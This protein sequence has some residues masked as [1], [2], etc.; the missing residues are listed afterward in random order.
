[1]NTEGK[2]LGELLLNEVETELFAKRDND[3]LGKEYSFKG[4]KSPNK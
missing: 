1:M 4:T 3:A 2:F